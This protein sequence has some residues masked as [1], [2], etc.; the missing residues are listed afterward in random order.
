MV[1]IYEDMCFNPKLWARIGVLV[2][3]YLTFKRK[4]ANFALV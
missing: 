1:K 2:E 4:N 3:T